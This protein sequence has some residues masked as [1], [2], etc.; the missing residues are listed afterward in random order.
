MGKRRVI[1]MIAACPFPSSQGSQVLIRQLSSALSRRGHSVHVITYPF[2]E[3]PPDP[4]YQ[5]H[6]AKALFPYGKLEPG[7]SLVKP[8]LDL[9]L[10]IKA[11]SV[12][13]RE[14]I[15]LLHG[16]NYEGGMVAWTAARWLGIP[17]IYHC[18]SLLSDELPTYFSA[19]PIRRIAR[20]FGSV[21][22]GIAAVLADH[23]IAVSPEIVRKF[24][25]TEE[26]R[27]KVTY[28][29]PGID[30]EEW[31]RI[32]L[33]ELKRVEGFRMVYTGNLA[34]FQNVPQLLE[35]IR[36]VRRDFHNVTLEV[37]TPSKSATLLDLARSIGVESNL[38][39]VVEKD[40][41]AIV[42]RLLRADLACSMRTMK[43]GF[44]VKNL[45]YMAAGLPIVCYESGAKG[46]IDRETGIVVKDNDVIA[47]ARAVSKLLKDGGLRNK[48]GERG[49]DIAFRNYNWD[50]LSEK[51]EEIHDSLLE[52]REQ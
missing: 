47:F 25:K 2:G 37:V 50:N 17:S 34:P 7:P 23:T 16:H 39:V 9:M 15:D 44:P 51:V 1:G 40:F 33:K 48:M 49:R 3:L 29:T 10:L 52:R 4:Y 12:A 26:R 30:P 31:G 11:I 21:F 8:I 41:K 45:N 22:D 42:P 14:K 20:L 19:R 24:T 46:V 18:H 43:S 6:R 13:R 38:S 5:L 27:R 36:T 35:A 28:L 32:D